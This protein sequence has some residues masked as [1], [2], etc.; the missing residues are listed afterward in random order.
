M[1]SSSHPTQRLLAIEHQEGM[2]HEHGHK[3]AHPLYPCK[4]DHNW[5]GVRTMTVLGDLIFTYNRGSDF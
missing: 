1:E 5:A 3:R 4:V 2:D